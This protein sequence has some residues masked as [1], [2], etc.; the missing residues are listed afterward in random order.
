MET[1]SLETLQERAAAG[2]R[3][4]DERM[5]GWWATIDSAALDISNCRNC[6]LGQSGGF[7]KQLRFLG[8]PTWVRGEGPA[9]QQ[10]R[11][12]LGFALDTFGI[13]DDLTD[14]W[15]AEIARRR[16]AALAERQVETAEMEAA[17]APH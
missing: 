8:I 4:L 3:L 13:V 6:V 12:L 11:V 1:L 17:H 15:R 2:A 9:D 7:M 14:C 5:P 16:M 10:P